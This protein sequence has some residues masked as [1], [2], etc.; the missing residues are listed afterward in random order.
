[1]TTVVIR[2][3]TNFSQERLPVIAEPD[4]SCS[5]QAVPEKGYE[6]PKALPVV[7]YREK[8]FTCLHGPIDSCGDFAEL[9][10]RPAAMTVLSGSFFTCTPASRMLVN[11]D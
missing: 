2:S 6:Q 3:A 7:A 11:S 10:F 9:P 4:A 1:M 8:A 5:K